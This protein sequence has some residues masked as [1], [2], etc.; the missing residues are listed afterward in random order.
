[1]SL[2]TFPHVAIPLSCITVDVAVWPYL[3]AKPNT[4]AS[5]TVRD[6]ARSIQRGGLMAS[7][8]VKQLWGAEFSVVPEGLSESDVVSFVNDLLE[9][10]KGNGA[11]AE[12]HSSLAQLAEKTVIEAHKLAESIKEQATRDGEAEGEKIAKLAGEKAR[13]QAHRTTEAA[14]NE[15]Q[16]NLKAVAAQADQ[17]AQET[18]R[19]ARREAQDILQA[20]KQ[21]ADDVASEA[22][23][24]AEYT[25]RKLTA[26]VSDEIRTAVATISDSILPDLTDAHPE[27]RDDAPQRESKRST[28]AAGAKPKKS[29]S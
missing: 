15:A 27:R 28:A 7:N 24:E 23:L 21:Q 18:L 9:R 22:K 4:R 10:S 5:S 26:K 6:D 14:E 20:A 29:S 19:K 2:G 13:E 16:A 1:M 12:R 25:V 3:T 11:E 8:G 17:Q